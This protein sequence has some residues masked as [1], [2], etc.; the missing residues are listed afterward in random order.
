MDVAGLFLNCP[1]LLTLVALFFQFSGLFLWMND[2]DRWRS[3]RGR[4]GFALLLI[5]SLALP[6]LGSEFIYGDPLG[7]WRNR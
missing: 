1:I 7:F 6:F 4:L 5:G 3:W 2:R